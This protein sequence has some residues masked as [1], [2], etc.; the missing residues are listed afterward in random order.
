MLIV[1]TGSGVDTCKWKPFFCVYDYPLHQVRCAV[2]RQSQPSQCAG[3]AALFLNSRRW[4]QS[5]HVQ[6]CNDVTCI[7]V[8]F[9]KGV[10]IDQY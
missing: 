9:E 4:Y 8:V 3:S 2:E 10:S 5:T 7:G 1:C 6:V